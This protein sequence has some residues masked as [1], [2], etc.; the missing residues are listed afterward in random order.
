M[1]TTVTENG[2]TSYAAQHTKPVTRGL[3]DQLTLS[4]YTY[5]PSPLRPG[6][7]QPLSGLIWG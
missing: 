7:K 3:V 6:L 5:R 1:I 2:F 4:S